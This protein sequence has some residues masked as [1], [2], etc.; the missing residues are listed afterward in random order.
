MLNAFAKP[1][2]FVLPHQSALKRLLKNS[3]AFGVLFSLLLL[4]TTTYGQAT[5]G[6]IVGTATDISGAAVLNVNIVV[7]NQET[8]A[9]RVVST[10]E[11][12][13]YEV[14]N[15]DP[16]TYTICGKSDRV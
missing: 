2:R 12:G 4:P 9:S 6:A 5:V 1:K 14:S 16:G 13:N 15:L 10:D 11:R 8:N 7:T 3:S